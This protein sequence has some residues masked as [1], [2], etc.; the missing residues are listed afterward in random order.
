VFDL[1]VIYAYLDCMNAKYAISLLV[2]GYCLDFIGGLFKI[3]HT[4]EADIMLTIAVILKVL[5][6]LLFLYK[7]TN[8]PKIKEFLD[9]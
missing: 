5:G 3:L 6:G 4:A 2:F 8:Y 9:R 1:I 7:L